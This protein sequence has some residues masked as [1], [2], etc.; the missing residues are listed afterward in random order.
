[1]PW[2][3]L[4]YLIVLF[5]DHTHLLYV[6]HSLFIVTLWGSCV[7]S[8][9]LMLYL[10]PFLICEHLSEEDR[11]GRF[12]LLSSCR[13]M[14]VSFLCFLLSMSCVCIQHL[15]TYDTLIGNLPLFQMLRKSSLCK[16][17]NHEHF[18]DHFCCFFY[19]IC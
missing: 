19:L 16:V 11:A 7:W 3:G 5:P 1:M 9:C 17:Q 8:V 10:V 6:V 14:P 15:R 2:V 18:N 13:H 12:T 4:Q